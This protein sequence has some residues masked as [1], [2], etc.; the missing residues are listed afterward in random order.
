MNLTSQCYRIGLLQ[1][2]SLSEVTTDLSSLLLTHVP[3]TALLRIIHTYIYWPIMYENH[4]QIRNR[5]NSPIC[6][7]AHIVPVSYQYP[8]LINSLE[9]VLVVC[10]WVIG[11]CLNY[12]QYPHDCY[13]Q[14][15][16]GT[17]RTFYYNIMFY[18]IMLLSPTRFKNTFISYSLWSNF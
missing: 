7:S 2:L 17:T 13:I 11:W 1:C 9:S 3:E 10:G 8:I 16:I 12:P 18:S 14:H 5:I 6:N 4:Q 15:S